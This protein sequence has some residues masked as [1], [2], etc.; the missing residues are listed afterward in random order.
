MLASIRSL[1]APFFLS[2]RLITNSQRLALAKLLGE[3]AAKDFSSPSAKYAHQ[4]YPHGFVGALSPKREQ[5]IF[6]QIQKDPTSSKEHL[7]KKLIGYEA[8]VSSITGVAHWVQETLK[9]EG[10]LRLADMDGPA[11]RCKEFFES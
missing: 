8:A 3:Q 2:K 6:E 1:D 9:N 11:L 5:E 10:G 4:L 7:P